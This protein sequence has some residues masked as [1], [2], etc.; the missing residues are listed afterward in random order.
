[1]DYLARV[2]ELKEEWTENPITTTTEGGAKSVLSALVHDSEDK[3]FSN[4]CSCPEPRGAAGC[5]P[6]SPVCQSCG[7]TWYCRTCGGCRQCKAPGPKVR[8]TGTIAPWPLGIG[9]LD[10]VLVEQVERDNV[11]LGIV[12]PV[13]RR[14]AVMFT[15]MQHYQEA[16][17]LELAQELKAAYWELRSQATDVIGLVKI[18]EHDQATLLKR[19]LTGQKWLTEFND[20]L[21]PDDEDGAAK[22]QRGLDRWCDMEEQLRHRHGYNGCVHGVD[23]ACPKG[24]AVRCDACAIETAAGLIGIEELQESGRP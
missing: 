9:L 1:M 22:L 12:D 14:L 7:Y 4:S 24:S 2:R 15:L 11:R 3:G 17:D 18:G 5:G 23:G 10:P 21:E 16:G 20:E 6:D 8:P 13:D 19:L